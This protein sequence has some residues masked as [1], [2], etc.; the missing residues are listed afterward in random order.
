VRIRG[1][2]CELSSRFATFHGTDAAKSRMVMAVAVPDRR[3]T[4][5]G[6]PRNVRP[7]SAEVNHDHTGRV[8]PA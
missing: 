6:M 5:T 2:S 3:G 4:P 1:V 7:L 8:N